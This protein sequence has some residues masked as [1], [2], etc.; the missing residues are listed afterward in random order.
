MHLSRNAA[1][2]SG[3]RRN[4]AAIMSH[5]LGIACISVLTTAH[6]VKAQEYVSPYPRPHVSLPETILVPIRNER[7]SQTGGGWMLTYRNCYSSPDVPAR[8]VHSRTVTWKAQAR[9]IGGSVSW[10]I[11]RTPNN[12]CTD[13]SGGPCPDT[14]R[15]LSVPQGFVAVPNI[16]RVNEGENRIIYIVPAGVI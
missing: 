2:L 11:I 3:N 7:G 8:E 1:S 15:I 16:E 10:E 4:L 5:L 9:T 13:Y 14:I 6:P 12:E